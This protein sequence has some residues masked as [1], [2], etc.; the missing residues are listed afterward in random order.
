MH[1]FVRLRHWLALDVCRSTRSIGAGA[2]VAG[3]RREGV[4]GSTGG[5]ALGQRGER[6]A[7]ALEPTRPPSS[8]PANQAGRCA[9]RHSPA[10]PRWGWGWRAP[11]GVDD[12]QPEAA[13]GMSGSRVGGPQECGQGPGRRCVGLEGGRIRW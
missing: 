13:D 7:S 4:S 9:G 5:Q 11:A 1:T 6:D 12:K 3:F 2:R 8:P 10:S